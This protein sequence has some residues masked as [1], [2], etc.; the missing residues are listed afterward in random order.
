MKDCFHPRPVGS[1]CM[2]FEQKVRTATGKTSTEQGRLQPDVYKYVLLLQL[3]R[4]DWP[5]MGDRT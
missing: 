2:V 4:S 1:G 5:D 3:G